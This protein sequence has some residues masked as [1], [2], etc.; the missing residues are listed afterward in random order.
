MNRRL[1]RLAPAGMML[2]LILLSLRPSGPL[3][4]ADIG[5]LSRRV[6]HPRLRFLF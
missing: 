3:D 2:S 4:D 1:H 6:Q 5:H